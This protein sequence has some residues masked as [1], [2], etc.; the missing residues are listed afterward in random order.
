MQ[1]LLLWRLN[2]ASPQ[3]WQPWTFGV[4][5]YHLAV[6]ARV[7]NRERWKG[8]RFHSSHELRLGWLHH[9]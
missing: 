9:A 6:I 1:K 8:A 4:I 5:S 7:S 3:K 2:L